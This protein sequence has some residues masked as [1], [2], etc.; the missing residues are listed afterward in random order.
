MRYVC[1]INVLLIGSLSRRDEGCKRCRILVCANTFRY[2][3]A[4]AGIYD[5][6][7]V[8]RAFETILKCG[9]DLITLCF[10]LNRLA[11]AN[12]NL[13][14]YDGLTLRSEHAVQLNFILIGVAQNPAPGTSPEINNNPEIS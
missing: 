4:L 2:F 8:C 14:F 1:S 5:L 12:G 10:F 7:E 11:V 13:R 9:G 6:G 3:F